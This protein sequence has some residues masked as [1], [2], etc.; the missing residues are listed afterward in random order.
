MHP[1]QI[2]K[3]AELELKLNGLAD[4]F[5]YW[6][7]RTKEGSALEKHNSQVTRLT[8]QLARV[9]AKLAEQ[10]KA[11]GF[12][13]LDEARSTE[14]DVLAVHR[15]W[16]FF[17]SKLSQRDSESL[18][19]FLAAA[20]DLAWACYQPP[21]LAMSAASPNWRQ[22]LKEPPLSFLNGG[23]S[24]FV[25]VRNVAFQVEDTLED[26]LDLEKFGRLVQKLPI[27][28]VGIPWHELSHLP[29]ILVIGHEIGHAV[30]FDLGLTGEL[31]EALATAGLDA[32]RLPAWQSWRSEAF[33][34][35]FGAVA[36]GPAFVGTLLD[37]LVE[38]KSAIT[39][40]WRFGPQWDL[41]PTVALRAQLVLAT[42]RLTGHAN[43]AESREAEWVR[44]YGKTHA[45]AAFDGDIARVAKA[46]ALTSFAALGGATLVSLVGFST[47]MQ[48]R[49]ADAAD[50]LLE[51]SKPAT[52]DPREV[53]AGVRLAFER[54]PAAL[55]PVS[56]G[57]K[58]VAA[59]ALSH[60]EAVRTKGVRS[61][62]AMDEAT[63]HEQQLRDA[64]AGDEWLETLQQRTPPKDPG[65]P[66]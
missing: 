11:E 64:V 15:I 52:S 36:C 62:R 44:L 10:V 3:R 18:H 57:G 20:D 17:R 59:R 30:E 7:A 49:A 66:G 34:D 35:V 46:F 1:M 16:D 14:T 45:M 2:R 55:A 42:I 56:R 47:D 51:T 58:G 33:A 41:Y 6:K 25:Q 22:S 53:L 61:S 23:S 12:D 26:G 24:P 5:T 8:R 32:E 48:E 40:E 4:E 29:E 38:P 39:T 37:F 13:V 43:D 28:V 60:L 63:S 27:P 54:K 19:E 50:A 9:H 21:S 31:K 65:T